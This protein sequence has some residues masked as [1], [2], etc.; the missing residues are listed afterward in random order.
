VNENQAVVGAFPPFSREEISDPI[1]VRMFA[2]R[3]TTK[4]S[5]FF[6][7]WSTRSRAGWRVSKASGVVAVAAK[8]IWGRVLAL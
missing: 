8:T 6:L 4:T 5:A 2:L 7:V 3:A 1:V